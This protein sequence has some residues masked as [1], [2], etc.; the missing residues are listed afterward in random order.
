MQQSHYEKV[1]AVQSNV[2]YALVLRG[3]NVEYAVAVESQLIA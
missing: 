3:D 1:V 2:T